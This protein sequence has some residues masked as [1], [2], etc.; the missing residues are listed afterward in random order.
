VGVPAGQYILRANPPSGWTLK[1]AFLNGRDLS[2]TPFELGSRDLTGV[3]LTF[4]DR[5]AAIV[6]SVRSGNAADSAAVV[7]AFPTDAAAWIGRG[8]FPRRVRTARA[9]VDGTYT[10]S[11]LVPGEYY[12]AAVKE[13]ALGDAQDPA[14]LEALTRVAQQV[15]VVDGERRRQDLTTAVVR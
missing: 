3:V 15:R 11:A 1:G 8:P 14:V 4:T 2:D 7:V 13:E 5:P 9:G 12:V 10:I 6:G